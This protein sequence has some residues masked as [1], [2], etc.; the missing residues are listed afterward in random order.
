LVSRGALP[1]TIVVGLSGSI[2]PAE[3]PSLCR[4]VRVLV[5]AGSTDLVVDVSAL[6]FP[7]MVAVD[8]LARMQ[9][10][11]RRLG[12]EITVMHACRRLAELLILTGLAEVVRPVER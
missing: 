10:T 6:L 2:D 12:R 9:L 4:R 8:A 1:S 5:L 11:A 3:I 7:D